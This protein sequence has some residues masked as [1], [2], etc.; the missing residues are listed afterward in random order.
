MVDEDRRLIAHLLRRAG[1][2]AGPS[3]ID[4]AVAAGYEATVED[5]LDTESHARPDEDLLE[6]FHSEHCD[7]ES[8]R[9][10]ALKWV[11]RMINSTR[12]LEEKMAL[13]WHGVFATGWA[14]VK[15]G[16]M[17]ANQNLMLRDHGLGDYRVLLQK[18][19]RDP[20]MIYWLDQ[21][22]NHAEAVNENYGRELLELFSM[23]RGNYTEDDVRAC[24]RAFSGW[25]MTHVLPRYPTGYWPAEF[26]YRGEDHDD[27]E[28]TFLGETGNFNGDDVIDIIV[29]QPATGTFVAREIY[30]F[31]V[32]DEIDDD[33]VEQ[34]ASV[35]FSSDYDMRQVM[36]F[37]FNSDFFKAALFKRVKSPIEFIVGTVRLTGEHRDA[38]QFGLDRLAKL[39]GMMGQELLN[40]PTV[41]GWHTGRE[42]IDSAFLVER[43]NFVT[44]KFSAGEAPGIAEITRRI[45]D[46]RSSIA[47]EDLLDTCAAEFV[48]LDLDDATRQVISDELT[49]PEEVPC[50][51]DELVGAVTEI[52]ALIGTS[53]EYQMA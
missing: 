23:G 1:F 30:Q 22:M 25:T 8:P 2:G 32:A 51:G 41:E 39:S 18:L 21:Q 29:R 47:R 16:Q 44:E 20:A 9:W 46:G 48:H 31:F 11:Y 19:S 15:N 50:G 49:S 28:K 35:Y 43:L 7:E 52:L 45:S 17:M 33:A 24:A 6:R 10:M 12:P 3:E 4:A 53:K 36:R 14:K 37:V 38:Y 5:L 27:G 40:P 26:E 42:W 13:M 34:I